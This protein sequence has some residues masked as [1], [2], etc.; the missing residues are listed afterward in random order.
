[1]LTILQLNFQK[2]IWHKT[3]LS[4]KYSIQDREISVG[5]LLDIIVK[6]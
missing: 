3:N 4:W 5:I 2:L 1:M 6:F